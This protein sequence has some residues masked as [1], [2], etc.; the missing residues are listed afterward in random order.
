MAVVLH[1]AQAVR[2]PE[3]EKIVHSY[4]DTSLFGSASQKEEQTSPWNLCSLAVIKRDVT[5]S[6]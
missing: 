3:F 2:K 5:Y 6:L 4:L 1:L